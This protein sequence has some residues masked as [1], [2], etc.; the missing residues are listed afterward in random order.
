MWSVFSI[1]KYEN[2]ESAMHPLCCFIAASTSSDTS[3]VSND[4]AL[5]DV[6]VSDAVTESDSTA[7]ALTA[8]ES[9]VEPCNSNVTVNKDTSGKS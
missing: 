4:T 2:E 9:A 7:S 8:A 5:Q 6:T 1:C 3:V